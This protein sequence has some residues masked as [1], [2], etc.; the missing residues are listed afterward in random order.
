MRQD[1]TVSD[2]RENHK[3][4]Y[5]R[6]TSQREMFKTVYQYSKGALL[7]ADMKK[8]EEIADD[9]C[10]VKNYVYQRYGGINSIS[11]LYPGY[12]VQNEM[13]KS[14][15]RNSLGLPAV[16][17]YCA[18]F[19]ALGDIKSQWSHARTKIEKNIRT[20]PD[21]NPEERH[22]L[23]F[24]IKQ[25]QC[26]TAI[27]SGKTPSAD[28]NWQESY[29]TLRASVNAKRLDQYLRRQVRKH[30]KKLHTNATDG[31]SVTTKG[32]RY[33]DHGIYLSTKENRK[34]IFIPLTD[35]NHYERQIHVT[36]DPQTG[37]IK[38]SIPVA[39]RVKA[40]PDYCNEIGL[41]ISMT[42]MF[43]TDQG[44]VYGAEFG[45]HQ[46]AL[47]EYIRTGLTRYRKNSHHNPGRKKYYAKKKRLETTLHSYINAEINRMLKTEKPRVIYLPKLPPTPTAG[48]IRKI[49]Y[50][51]NMWQRGYVKKR[52]AQKCKEHTI[53]FVEVFGKD[54]SNVCSRCGKH[55]IKKHGVFT[56][57]SCGL[58]LA[59][60]HNTAQNAKN[61]GKA[62]K[63]QERM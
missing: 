59:E 10:K 58:K 57:E 46:T 38:L 24:T 62:L 50:S 35:N 43:I 8:L 22:Y 60:K 4:K 36:I 17:F 47:T 34:R 33:G 5:H 61:R 53:E 26:F 56:C 11:K 42:K 18:I 51:A 49:N 14:G 15:L 9:Y 48:D 63:E 23:R 6:N 7:P 39:I 54:I 37:K 32:Y 29:S 13:T 19:D 25:S 41:A 12:T 3:E 44:N 2:K 1:Y 30:L 52:L 28:G 16:Y 27:L 21:L 45:I 40:R 55:G 31:F 20:H